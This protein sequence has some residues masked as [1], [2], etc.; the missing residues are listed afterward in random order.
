MPE[1]GPQDTLSFCLPMLALLPTLFPSPF[2][3]QPL[4]AQPLAFWG[5]KS[6]HLSAFCFLSQDLYKYSENLA[7]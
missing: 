5:L 2:P 7:F 3:S 4:P 1:M 6:K